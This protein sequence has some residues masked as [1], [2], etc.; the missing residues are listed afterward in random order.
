MSRELLRPFAWTLVGAATACA[1][2]AVE[3]IDIS[4]ITDSISRSL[5]EAAEAI[6]TEA[7][8]EGASNLGKS[9]GDAADQAGE[10]IE[11]LFRGD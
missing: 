11:G 8:E 9:I 5:D 2:A 6:D 10:D 4:E 7:I 1:G 3:A